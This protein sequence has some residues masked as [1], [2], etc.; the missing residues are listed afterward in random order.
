[1]VEKTAAERAREL[2]E[3]LQHHSYLYYVLDQPEISDFEFDKLYRELVELE[4][5]HPELIAPDSPTQRVGA[6]PSG[7]FSKVA[8]QFPLYSLANA[9]SIGEVNAFVKRIQERLGGAS[10]VE[11]VTELKIDGLAINLIYENGHLTQCVTRGDGEV[12]EDVTANV[13]TIRSLPLFI[14]NAPARLD[15]RG[16]VYMPRRAFVELN[17]ARDENGEAPFAN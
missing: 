15:I 8:H 17:E 5:A 10:Q 1:M 4:T 16:E 12:G 11:Y 9:F 13:K 7:A 14:K 2:R 6:A 3:T